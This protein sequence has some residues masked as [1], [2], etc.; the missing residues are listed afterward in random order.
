[1]SLSRARPSGRRPGDSGTREAILRAAR[2]QFAENGYDRTSLRSIAAEAG[3]DPTLVSHFHGSKQQLFVSVV[4]LPFRPAEVLPALLAGDRGAIGERVARFVLGVLESE[5]G[6]SRVVGLLRA[7]ASDEQAARMVRDLI[8][9]ELFAPIAEH[10]GTD[11]PQL[12]ASL[13]GAQV[14]GLAMARH[15]VGVEPLASADADTVAA[16]LAPNLQRLLVEPLPPGA[17][18]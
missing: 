4:E 15:V 9:A 6:R 17:R 12:R 3:V 5:E 16:I 14:V 7:A 18:G 11:Q 13:I 10:L 1:M 2:R 8:V